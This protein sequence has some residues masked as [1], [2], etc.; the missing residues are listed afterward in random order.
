[1]RVD[2]L[3]GAALAVL[4]AVVAPQAANAAEACPN[5]QL[6]Q[7]SNVNPTTHE[8]YDLQLPEC[9][10]YEM[11]S[12]LD[13]QAHDASV[14]A[15]G[16]AVSPSGEAIEYA[17]E[18]AFAG[19][20]NY[21]ATGISPH[22]D[23]IS[24][25]TVDGWLTEPALVPASIISDPTNRSFGG[26]ASI[27]LTALATCGSVGF[28]NAFGQ[29]GTTFDCARR[30]SAESWAR[31]PL[32]PNLNGF[33]SASG[34]FLW[35]SSADLADIVWQ[36]PTGTELAL[37]GGTPNGGGAIYETIGLGTESPELRLVSVNNEGTPLWTEHDSGSPYV[38]AARLFTLIE[39]SAD[40]AVS[41]DG[42][43]VYFTAEPAGG[44]PLTLYARTG[45]FAGGT[46]ASPLTVEIAHNATY[47]G[48]S[49]DGSKVFFTTAEKL[50]STDTDRTSDLYEYNFDASGG[51]YIQLSAGGLGDAT[52]RSGANVTTVDGIAS[53]GSHIYFGSTAALTTIPNGNGEHASQGGA[54]I[55]GYSTETGDTKFVATAEVQNAHGGVNEQEAQV[56]PSGVYL[57][58]AT[59]ARGL[60]SQDRNS[61]AAIYRYDFQTGELTWVSHTA[62]GFTATNEGDSAILPAF[63]EER[64]GANAD[65]AD[66]R[67]A[68]SESGEYIVFTT[69]ERLQED[70]VNKAANVYLWHDG[71]VHMISDGTNPEGVNVNEPP[72]ISASGS[73]VVFA[74]S[75]KLVRR[76]K[77]ELTDIYDARI[78]G[79][80]PAPLVEPS[81]SGEA[82]QGTPTAG[83]TFA[84]P[85][86]IT[87]A[88]SGNLSFATVASGPTTAAVK[89]TSRSAKNVSVL[90]PAA[91]ALVV[92][93]AGLVGAQKT[94]T[95]AGTYALA[96]ALTKAEGKLLAKRGHVTVTVTVRFTP[97]TGTP[98][99]ATTE[100]T[101]KKKEKQS[102]K[103]R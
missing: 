79:G 86:S 54:N 43:T 95:K 21:Q 8:P 9:R 33:T 67:R 35:G 60:V 39:G 85:N 15:V 50:A 20:E 58:F 5:E 27:D 25:R 98:S 91:G 74:T 38:G 77:D 64:E 55:Y 53:D 84:I 103:R 63:E 56:T 14:G 57:V 51:H 99:S 29:G 26:D 73:D 75:S 30:S 19:T 3:A 83:R 59:K 52:P 40:Q 44:G 23:Y 101:I 92:S 42:Q 18:G 36:S 24:R 76:D 96:L 70:D 87:T 28:T 97:T 16:P 22:L 6:R 12:P 41:L 102:K 78:D 68:I 81:C 1:M 7:E 45:D 72:A 69:T 13:K 49:A 89:I 61:G 48:A 46:P 66:L 17:S 82:C 93:G 94:A 34:S 90:T 88:P 31:S 10:A 71:E 80:F 11:V 32:Y 100:I 65:F 2:L 4:V 37:G 47:W 62:Q